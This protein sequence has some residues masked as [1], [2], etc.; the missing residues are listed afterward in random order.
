M[1]KILTIVVPSYN[2]EK[3]ILKNIPFLLDKD[4]NQYIE[5]LIINDGSTDRTEEYFHFCGI[6]F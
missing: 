2:T 6:S 3:F 1:R 5:V 4:I